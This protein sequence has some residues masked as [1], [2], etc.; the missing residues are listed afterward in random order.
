M[1]LDVPRFGYKL[2]QK[3][4]QNTVRGG[5]GVGGGEYKVYVGDD[6]KGLV[7]I[8]MMIVQHCECN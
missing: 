3:P 8:V 6:F 4:E 2:V 7:K 1:V 5:G